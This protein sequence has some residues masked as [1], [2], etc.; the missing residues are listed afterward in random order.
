MTSTVEKKEMMIEKRGLGELQ[1]KS[2]GTTVALSKPA[3][4]HMA[5]RVL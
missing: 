5:L 3:K 2:R 1:E 4:N